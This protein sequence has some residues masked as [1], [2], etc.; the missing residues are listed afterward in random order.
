MLLQPAKTYFPGYQCL[1]LSKSITR[2]HPKTGDVY[3]F[4]GQPVADFFGDSGNRGH[5]TVMLDPG[6]Y[7][8]LS[9]SQESRINVPA[10]DFSQSYNT[11]TDRSKVAAGCSFQP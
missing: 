8:L 2:A 5:V 6:M 7:L 3:V 11:I 10:G 1:D 4:T 9:G